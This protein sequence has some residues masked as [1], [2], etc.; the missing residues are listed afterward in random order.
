MKT[1]LRSVRDEAASPPVTSGEYPPAP[2]VMPGC[3]R[4][5]LLTVVGVAAAM[6]LGFAIRAVWVLPADFPLNDGGLFLLM[7]EAMQRAL[8]GLPETVRY[9]GLDIPFAYPPLA[10]ASAAALGW[11]G[12]SPLDA[13]RYLPLA[14]NTLSIGALAVLA[15]VLLIRQVAVVVGTLLFAVMPGSY[16]WLIMGGGLTRSFGFLFALLGLAAA[17]RLSTHHDRR[18]II[19]LG[20]FAALTALS[21]LE[22]AWFLAVGSGAAY[23]ALDRSR[24][25]LVRLVAAGLLAAAIAAP[26]WLTVLPRYGLGPWL[27][28]FQTAS[29]ATEIPPEASAPADLGEIASQTL[30]IICLAGLLMVGNRPLAL[31]A[32]IGLMVFLHSRSML[33]LSAVPFALAI[34]AWS[35]WLAAVL[36]RATGK[37]PAITAPPRRRGAVVTAG[38]VLAIVFWLGGWISL[39]FQSSLAG[40][41]SPLSPAQRA[42]MRWTSA[43][44]PPDSRFAVLS[45]DTWAPDRASEWFPVLAQRVSVATPQGTEWLPGREFGRRVHAHTALQACA[46]AGVPC[47]AAWK[48]EAG[49]AFSHVY[50][51]RRAGNPCCEILAAALRADPRFGVGFDGPGA[52]IFTVPDD[53]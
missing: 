10:F 52:A 35:G 43:M 47:L 41:L 16:L 50:I 23:L 31:L 44:T 42:A 29:V 32:W 13:L 8:P 38:I 11:F 7:V 48:R 12:V 14:V 33:W 25:G 51:A 24:D 49:L 15:R 9:N 21:H 17:C 34:G 19:V 30:A 45:G 5:S 18:T 2:H 4:R 3:T 1:L 20:V 27:A 53:L 37:V 39:S 36:G 26:W 6:A 40:F 28:A 22:M 46:R